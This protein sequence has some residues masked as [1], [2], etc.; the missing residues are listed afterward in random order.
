MSAPTEP[1]PPA[2]EAPPV[3]RKVIMVKGIVVPARRVPAHPPAATSSWR[4]RGCTV[5][6][7]VALAVVSPLSAILVYFVARGILGNSNQQQYVLSV[8]VPRLISYVTSLPLGVWLLVRARRGVKNFQSFGVQC[9]CWWMIVQGVF[10]IYSNIRGLDLLDEQ[11]EG[12]E[13]VPLHVPDAAARWHRARCAAWPAV[14][15]ALVP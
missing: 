2:T 9:L 5:A 14:A 8:G 10:F 7:A 15:S 11:Y 6:L 13:R 4:V 3:E 12:A 1:S